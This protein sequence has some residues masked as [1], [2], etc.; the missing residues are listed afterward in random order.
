MAGWEESE[1]SGEW[2]GCPAKSLPQSQVTQR[3]FSRKSGAAESPQRDNLFWGR[4]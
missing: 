4:D 1:A 3:G 2:M